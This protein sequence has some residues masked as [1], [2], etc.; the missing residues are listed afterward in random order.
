MAI[1]L[2]EA[3]VGMADKID[4]QV[5]DQFRRNSLLLDRLDF[6]NSVSPG[7]G[8]STLVYGYTRLKTPAYATFRALNTEY[9]SGEAKREEKTAKLAIFGGS[10]NLDRVIIDTAGAVNEL[11]FQ[12][13]QKIKAATNHF[14]YHVINGDTGVD[15]NGFD[16]LDKALI[17]SSTEINGTAV[18]D[19]STEANLNSNY[20]AFL[21]LLD[22]MTAELDG[23]SSVFMVNSKM[24]V[25]INSVARRAGYYSQVE[26]AFGKQVDA[27]RGIPIM[28][29][30]W[31]VK[32]NAGTPTTEP[33][34]GI[35]NRTVGTAQ[36]GLTDIYTVRFGL[37]GFH[38]AT[39]TGNNVIKTYLPDL[40]TPGAVKS[41]E[42]EMV[43][44]TVLKNTR[45]AAVL[46]NIKI[47]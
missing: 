22:S 21:D 9:T 39:V 17:G 4:Q 38:G 29:L 5:V 11:D 44:T 23:E 30:G 37:D 14:H 1:T 36:T 8:G 19:L 16:G 42:I 27:F 45:A 18:L 35:F 2:A 6:D 40:T 34:V 15:A 3:K 46:R 33:V 12:M 31:H 47:Q 43:A 24:K 20:N 28:D 32:D 7:T 41:G 13:N 25:K 26:T 10:F